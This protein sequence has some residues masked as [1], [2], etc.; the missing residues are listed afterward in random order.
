MLKKGDKI[1]YLGILF[2]SSSLTIKLSLLPWQ[3]SAHRLPLHQALTAGTT[4]LC[5]SIQIDLHVAVDC[6]ASEISVG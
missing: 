5:I 4:L 6:A 3:R 1:D 2:G